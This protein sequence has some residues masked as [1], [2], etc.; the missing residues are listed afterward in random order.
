MHEHQPLI[1]TLIE[2]PLPDEVVGRVKDRSGFSN[3][4]FIE[5]LNRRGGL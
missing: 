2:A 4:H 5:P 3:F 1:L